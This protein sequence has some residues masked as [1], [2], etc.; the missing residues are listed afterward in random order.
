MGWATSAREAV[1]KFHEREWDVIITDLR[2]VDGDGVSVLKAI[3]KE[4]PGTISIVLTGFPTLESAI[5]AI[6]AGVHDYLIKPCKVEDM[7]K[8]IRRGLAKREAIQVEAVAKRHS[9]E[10]FKRIA[11][12]NLKLKAE[13]RDKRR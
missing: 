13:L 9:M 12:E 7:L 5:A 10:E 4:S 1:Q 2:L 3:Y 6:R 8:S 11:H